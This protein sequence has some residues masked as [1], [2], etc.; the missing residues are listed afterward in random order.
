MVRVRFAPS[1]TG[2]LHIGS[3]RTAVFNWLFARRYGGRFLL[4]IEDTDQKRSEARYLEEILKDLRWLGI[5]W[6]EE[7]VFQSRRFDI[8]RAK[9]EELVAAGKAYREGEAVLFRVEKG[10]TIEYKDMIH[11]SI[12][13]QTDDIKDQV[14]IKSDGSPAYNFSC[15]VDDGFM[16]ISHILRGDDHVSNTPKQILFYEALGL[17]PP[18]F[19]HM[20]LILGPDGSKLSKRHGGVS[21]EEYKREGFLPQAL[22]N[23]LFLLGWSP[24]EEREILSLE[25]AVKIFDVAAMNAVQA[26]FDIQKLRWF[27]AEY[28]MKAGADELIPLLRIQLLEAGFDLASSDDAY[29]G[30]VLELYRVRIKTLRDFPAMAE[31][32]FRDDFAVEEG[33]RALLDD[34]GN[35]ELIAD[36][37][38]RL[39][40]GGPFGHEA[41]EKLFR[42]RAAERGIKPAQLI[43]PVRMA[44]S[45]RSKG[46]GLF[47]MMEVLGKE[48][49]LHRLRR[50]AHGSADKA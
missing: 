4:R 40:S 45:G 15:V 49:V 23:Y 36:L 17:R 30:R 46:A 3:A 12:A 31:C 28:I 47:E 8:Y 16:G 19:G 38:V 18:E 22:A 43:H 11:G 2:F 24:G 37:A 14:L 1:P 41:V 7:P 21:V 29:I 27:N 48:T 44:V 26:K 10:R 35:R 9:A 20:P 33:G 13:W 6:D 34:P 42:E 50:V 39:E 32:F 5:D 25:E